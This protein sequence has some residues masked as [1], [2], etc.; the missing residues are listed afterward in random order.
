MR[1]ALRFQTSA[2]RWTPRS[3][4][5]LRGNGRTLVFRRLSGLTALR[6]FRRGDLDEVPVPLGDIGNFRSSPRLLHAQPLLALDAVI[7]RGARMPE[8]LRRAYWRTADRA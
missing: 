7:F 2:G 8:E 3:R 1:S 4:V 5:V 6:A